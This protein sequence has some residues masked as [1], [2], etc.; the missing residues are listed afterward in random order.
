MLMIRISLRSLLV[1][2][3]AIAVGIASFRHASDGWQTTLVS[4]AI[5]LFFFAAIMSL[6]AQGSRRAAAL[7]CTGAMAAYGLALF[8]SAP[9]GSPIAENR[10]FNPSTGRLPTSLLLRSLYERVADVG[11]VDIRTGKQ[12]AEFSASAAVNAGDS[13]TITT[14]EIP[15]REIFMVIGHCWWALALGCVGGVAARQFYQR[16][17]RERHS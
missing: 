4:V 7:G 17:I 2:V 8:L 13:A 14:G 12:A 15:D 3:T 9:W 6:V 5:V 10:E 16:R 11:W 1:L